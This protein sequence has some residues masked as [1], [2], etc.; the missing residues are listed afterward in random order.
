MAIG[1]TRVQAC[2]AIARTAIVVSLF[3]VKIGFVLSFLIAR[4]LGSLA[5][6][7]HIGPA[8][9][10]GVVVLFLALAAA[11]FPAWRAARADPAAVLRQS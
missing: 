7:V 10:A 11:I 4:L 6:A 1:S 9:L 3:S 8:V 2:A 5:P